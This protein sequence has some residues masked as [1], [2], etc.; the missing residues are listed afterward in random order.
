ML[1]VILHVWKY[2]RYF[3]TAAGNNCI[4]NV[5]LKCQIHSYVHL[6]HNKFFIAVAAKVIFARELMFGSE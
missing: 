2:W 5:S 4:V 1:T 6:F 3:C